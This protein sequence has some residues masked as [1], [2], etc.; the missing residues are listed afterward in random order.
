M[1][2]PALLLV[3][4]AGMLRADSPRDL[5]QRMAQA[6]AD[7]RPLD[8]LAAFDKA[9]PGYAALR[10]I[11]DNLLSR[12]NVQSTVELVSNSLLEW[13][14]HIVERGGTGGTT[15]RQARVA[16]RFEEK[17]GEWRMAAFDPD[18]L[19]APPRGAEAWNVLQSAAAALSNGS[20]A[21][22]LA[23]F[24]PAMPGYETLRAEIAALAQTAEV[25]SSIELVS[26]TGTDQART[27]EVDWTVEQ[28]NADTGIASTQR[29]QRAEC[30]LEWRDR[31][32][33]ITHLEPLDLFRA[34]KPT[35]R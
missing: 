4:L 10:S 14:L 29:R 30:R 15:D 33:R 35:P 9:M 32:W 31:R 27:L 18:G 2:R 16:C 24:D 3:I 20:A 22:F 19:F 34:A 25:E 17:G 23:Y 8:F 26:N 1:T 6:L 13:S 28:V 12:A 5:V 21:G 7:N 11:V